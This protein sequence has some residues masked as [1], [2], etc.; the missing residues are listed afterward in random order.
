MLATLRVDKGIVVI[1]GAFLVSLGPWW[2]PIGSQMVDLQ[3]QDTDW[4]G[5]CYKDILDT[6][7]LLDEFIV[8]ILSVDEGKCGYIGCISG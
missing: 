6:I 7:L 5:C 2:E 4:V 3:C 8:A 1:L